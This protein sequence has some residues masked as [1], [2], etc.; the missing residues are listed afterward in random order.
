MTKLLT[1]LR[2]SFW[3]VPT[4]I[5]ALCVALAVSAV[6]LDAIVGDD[7]LSRF[8]RL[9]GAGAEGARQLLSAIAGSTITVAGVVFSITIV[10][11]SLTAAQYS[12][13]VL[14]HFMGD[15]ANQVVLGTFVGIYVYC[16]LVLRTV[17]A[18][19][20]AFVPG[21]SIIGGLLLALLGVGVLIFFIH[22][23]AL[24]IQASHIAS[25][26]A[27]DTIAALPK[28]FPACSDEVDSSEAP[29]LDLQR[30][31]CVAAPAHGYIQQVNMSSLL[32]WSRAN[33]RIVRL[34]KAVG[35][36]VIRGHALLQVSGGHEVAERDLRHLMAAF[37]INT[38]RDLAE[39]PGFG[40][41]QLVDVA[42]KALSPGVNDIG[43][44]R[45]ALH[46]ITAVL[47]DLAGRS[48]R[49]RRY[50]Y[51]DDG[52]LGVVNCSRTFEQI[53]DMAL[54]PI[55][56]QSLGQVEMLLQLSSALGDLAQS[57][58]TQEHCCVVA[59]HARALEAEVNVH[60]FSGEEAEAFV[61]AIAA[62]RTR[63]EEDMAHSRGAG[64]RSRNLCPRFA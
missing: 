53:V 15:R 47:C 40:V 16:L 39:D 12:P 61:K 19:E 56:R 25:R 41:Q 8:P 9:F 50:L 35:E 59:K 30:W 55:R 11:L 10:A 49:E 31:H 37:A 18:G 44:A 36:F 48:A 52:A 28:V 23:V 14:R 51:H 26:V 64:E 38:Y 43:T 34:N 27:H 33:R 5:V 1:D 54:R 13:R 6:E 22:H 24:S 2:N 21:I 3:F 46:H 20:D 58:R 32:G 60:V 7:A 17:R 62:V 45:N 42:L 29:R 63:C 4:V 57:C